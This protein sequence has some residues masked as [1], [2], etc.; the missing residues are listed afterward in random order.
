MGNR[1]RIFKRLKPEKD[2]EQSVSELVARESTLMS[3][4]R[5]GGKYT[6]IVSFSKASMKNYVWKHKKK[7]APG[8]AIDDDF[9]GITVLESPEIADVE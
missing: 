6:S 7:R 1:S 9:L 4:A 3:F 8:L 2:E 5:Q